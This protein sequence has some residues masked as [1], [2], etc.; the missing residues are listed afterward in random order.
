MFNFNNK[1]EKPLL[2]LE[3]LGGG[4]GFFGGIPEMKLLR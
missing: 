3:G 1:K 4:V 2:G